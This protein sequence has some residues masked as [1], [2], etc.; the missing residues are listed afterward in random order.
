MEI[1]RSKRASSTG[2][3]IVGQ[4]KSK[5]RK[6]SVSVLSSCPI[7]LLSYLHLH[8]EPPLPENATHATFVKHLSGGEVQMAQGL[9]ATHVDYVSSRS[10][11][12]P[13]DA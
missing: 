11:P 4:Q 9:C 2:G 12:A 8:R 5:Y 13:L 3:S 1:I 6:R 7:D 10:P